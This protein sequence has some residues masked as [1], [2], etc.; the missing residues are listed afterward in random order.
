[1]QSRVFV[2]GL[3]IHIEWFK[4]LGWLVSALMQAFVNLERGDDG[5]GRKVGF[6]F[7]IK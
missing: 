3:K 4:A 5:S 6:N 7:L 2:S 1:M